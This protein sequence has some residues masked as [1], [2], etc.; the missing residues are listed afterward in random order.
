MHKIIKMV[1]LSEMCGH[2]VCILV[3]KYLNLS[4][5]NLNQYDFSTNQYGNTLLASGEEAIGDDEEM[6]QKSLDV[7]TECS[8]N[9]ESSAQCAIFCL[10]PLSTGAMDEC[11][12]AFEIYTCNK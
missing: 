2:G 3:R 4:L 10:I 5:I 6:L 8:V 12:V 7:A 9:G 1:V 11:S